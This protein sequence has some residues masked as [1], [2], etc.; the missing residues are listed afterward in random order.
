MKTAAT[1]LARLL[2]VK[3]PWHPVYG[4]RASVES[5]AG[6]DA[7]AAMAALKQRRRARPADG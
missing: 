1:S 7:T 5:Y 4:S 3:G 2:F 6:G